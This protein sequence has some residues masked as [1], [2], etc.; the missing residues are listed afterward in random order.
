MKVLFP[1]IG[2]T[3]GG[4][5]LSAMTLIK[6]LP[7]LQIRPIV[8]VHQKGLL[9]DLFELNGIDY[10]VF[11]KPYIEAP[12]GI[13][14]LLQLRHLKKMK[15][16]LEYEKIDIVHT[17]DGVTANNWLPAAKLAS[18][19]SVAHVRRLWRPSRVSD[20]LHFQASQFIAI[21]EFVFDSCPEIV[22]SRTSIIPNA[23]DPLKIT[24]NREV[25]TQTVKLSKA[26]KIIVIVG[27]INEQKRPE[28]AIE[29]A[30]LLHK[31]GKNISFLFIGRQTP[32]INKLRSIINQHGIKDQINFIDYTQDVCQYIAAADILVA[33][34]KNEGWGRTLLESMHLRTPVIASN[35]GGHAE[36]IKHGVNGFLFDTKAPEALAESICRII[37]Q[38][39]MTQKV[40]ERA[41]DYA[42]KH[43]SEQA[44]VDR[45]AK[46]YRKLIS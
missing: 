36:I 17:N 33:P 29:A 46:I 44:H 3:V 1:F 9:S 32:H 38:K 7:D 4:S 13:W 42:K 22:R 30:A 20:F 21:S 43:F 27:T 15:L 34:A 11:E 14:A 35:H 2:S 25:K 5:H 6:K 31:K 41:E 45:V 19:K 12:G 8:L 24:E 16:F 39:L 37:E 10:K 23:I 40:I 28:L 26:G 18:R